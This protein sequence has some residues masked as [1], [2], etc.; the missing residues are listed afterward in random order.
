M[1]DSL[2]DVA[3]RVRKVAAD[4]A[5]LVLNTLPR[6]AEAGGTLVASLELDEFIAV[7][8][9]TSPRIVYFFETSFDVDGAI[10]A[11]IDLEED[12]LEASL[13]ELSP[14][15]KA[16][17]QRMRRRN[18]EID[19]IA[20]AVMADG[21]LHS[22]TVTA[23]W[24]EEFEEQLDALAAEAREAFEEVR[25]NAERETR[26]RLEKLAET[27]S[28]HVAFPAA[29]SFERRCDLAEKLFPTLNDHELAE[30]TKLADKLA[31]LAKNTPT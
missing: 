18:G 23:P 10:E 27:L 16:L 1:S 30:V 19:M 11:A 25:E 26:F 14:E 5:S 31:W 24:A 17:R 2:T 3:E 29:R 28:Q 12:T 21:V 6:Q 4:A 9:A 8:K 20:A 22:V 15:L 7:I 13:S